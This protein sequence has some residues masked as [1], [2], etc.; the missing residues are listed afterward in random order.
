MTVQKNSKWLIFYIHNAVAKTQSERHSA[1]KSANII[2][3]ANKERTELLI[4]LQRYL[5]IGNR[6]L[7]MTS[8]HRH[9]HP[10]NYTQILI[11][12]TVLP[13]SLILDTNG[14]KNTGKLYELSFF[15]DFLIL[16]EINSVFLV[17]KVVFDKIKMSVRSMKMKANKLLPFVCVTESA[18][19]VI[20]G[21]CFCYV[22]DYYIQSLSWF[23]T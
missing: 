2:K 19:V 23:I 3:S 18:S 16:W 8:G 11:L 9:I 6:P 12:K 20:R 15:C 7:A 21:K 22:L 10:H 5:L 1:T 17:W 13:H 14:C 4:R